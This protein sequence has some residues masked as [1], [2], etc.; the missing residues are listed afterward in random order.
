MVL[1]STTMAFYNPDATT[2]IITDGSPVRLGAI[3]AQ[4]QENGEY[5]PITYGSQ[6]LTD[7][8]TR[9]SQTEKEALAVTWSCQHFHYY[10]TIDMLQSLLITNHSR[11]YFL[12]SQTLLRES[13]GGF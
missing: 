6:A 13:N 2:Q 12:H 7:T 8:E 9:Y 10:I 4:Q 11:N 3:L 5:K 1:N